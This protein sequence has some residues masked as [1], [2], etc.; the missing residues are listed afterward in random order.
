MIE[1]NLLPDVKLEFIKAQKIR[2][3]VIFSS[4]IIG[5]TSVSIVAGLAVYIFAVQSIRGSVADGAIKD[6][7]AQ[8]NKVE[9][10]PKI[11]TI[12]N[13]LS[14][15][16]ELNSD[17]KID[18]RIF[19]LLKVIIPPSPNN[20]QISDLVINPENTTITINGQAKNSYEALEMFKKII[21]GA[22][23]QYMDKDNNSSE[24]ALANSINTGNSS[25]GEDSSGQKVLRFTLSFAYA[26][27]LFSQAT[28]NTIVK[29]TNGGN[30]TDSYLSMPKIFTD[31]AKDQE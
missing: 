31:R 19:D 14:K 15:I 21:E 17:K 1:I 30:V 6:K 26:P 27:E 4:L 25:Y 3:K 23:V 22:K 18:S 10:L 24:V 7:T 12:Q 2:A 28:K 11:L 20:I 16:S 29:I 13:Q 9:D 8:L 5:I